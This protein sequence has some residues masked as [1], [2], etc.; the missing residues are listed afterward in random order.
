MSDTILNFAVRI[1]GSPVDPSS[2]LFQN[3][4]DEYGII[5]TDTGDIV[6]AS[7]TS[8][9]RTSLGSYTHTFEDPT[10]PLTYEFTLQVDYNSTTYYVTNTA[11]AGTKSFLLNIP[12]VE[13]YTS[14]AEVYRLMGEYAV[15]LM[16]DDYVGNGQ[17]YVWTDMLNHVDETINMYLMQHYD[18][19]NSSTIANSN[20]VRRRATVL[21]A[22]LLS[23][24]RGNNP[25]WVA[26]TERVYDELMS[27]RDGRFRIPDLIVRHYQG[28]MWRNY[29]I[30]NRFWQHPVRVDQT[31]SNKQRYNGQDDM[32][33]P[34]LYAIGYD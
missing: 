29:S 25:L 19:S 10:T 8:L 33:Y 6:V 9:T 34:Y 11:A 31:K 22:N 20:W 26:Q 13:H 18:V 5:R 14:Q 1:N 7:G 28:P 15:E 23:Q 2:I 3:Q 32:L 12:T 21:C 4:S 30:Q 16:I 24:R 17:G 27:I